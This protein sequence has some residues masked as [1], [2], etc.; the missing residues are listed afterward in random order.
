[1]KR[2]TLFHQLS[3]DILVYLSL[4]CDSTR[5]F[6]KLL[7]AT[8]LIIELNPDNNVFYM[9]LAREYLRYHGQDLDAVL[10]S[11]RNLHSTVLEE[12]RRG[13]CLCQDLFIARR[14]TRS[15]CLRSFE[16]WQNHNHACCFHPGR[17]KANFLTC[18][19]ARS[20]QTEG[21]KRSFHC[22]IFHFMLHS[23]RG[24][25]EVEEGGEQKKKVSH[26]VALPHIVTTS[27]S[28]H[29]KSRVEKT[30]NTGGTKL[31]AVK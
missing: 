4:Y 10:A 7:E 24:R 15:G 27:T 12:G 19:R 5:A 18:C 2:T 17:L 28:V 31:P 30:D 13:Y 6:I 26:V 8:K 29:V 16:E 14:C 22:G 21:C 1:M 25:R 23:D 11:Y 3:I 9:K 20:F